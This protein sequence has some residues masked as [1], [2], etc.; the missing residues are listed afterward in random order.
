MDTVGVV[1][2]GVDCDSPSEGEGE[3]FLDRVV[4]DVMTVLSSSPS[5]VPGVGECTLDLDNVIEGATSL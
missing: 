1:S 5:E 2:I 4:L 3:E